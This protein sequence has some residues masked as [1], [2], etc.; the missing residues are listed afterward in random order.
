LTIHDVSELPF[1]D[2]DVEAAGLPLAVERL[3]EVVGSGDGLL[4]FSP[5]YNGSFPAVTKNVIDWLS[6]PP[7]VWDD[8]PIALVSTSPGSR[9]GFGLREHF[10]AILERRPVRLFGTLGVGSVGDL[11]D[12]DGQ[13]ADPDALA[14]LADFVSRFADFCLEGTS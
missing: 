12:Q 2:G 6:R 8:L 14:E 1:Y 11:L 9:A 13:L 7:K 5:E 10:T 4:L 3:N